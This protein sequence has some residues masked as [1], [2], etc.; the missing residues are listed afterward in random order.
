MK[1]EVTNMTG[2]K[3]KKSMLWVSFG[4]RRVVFVTG[5]S[6]GPPVKCWRGVKVRGTGGRAPDPVVRPGEVMK[7][8]VAP[9]I[10]ISSTLS[11]EPHGSLISSELKF[12]RSLILCLSNIG[13]IIT[14]CTGPP[15][16]L[17]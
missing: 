14:F 4:R 13:L 3:K 8:D 7:F 15:A 2:R 1:V 5:W 9:K 11:R 16:L 6:T 12:H 10:K 17:L